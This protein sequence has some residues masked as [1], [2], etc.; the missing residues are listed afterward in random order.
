MEENNEIFKNILME[1]Y[2]NLLEQQK[3]LGKE[4]EQILNDNFWELLVET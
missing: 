4:F 2:K 3:P 1:F